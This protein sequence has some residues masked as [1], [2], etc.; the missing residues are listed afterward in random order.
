MVVSKKD[1]Q[2]DIPA[3]IRYL[4]ATLNADG[5]TYNV[6][7]SES[8]KARYTLSKM[9]IIQKL[10]AMNLLQAVEQFAAGDSELAIFVKD[11]LA[12]GVDLFRWDEKTIAMGEVLQIDL[13]EFFE[14][15]EGE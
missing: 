4:T 3:N 6:H 9:R 7:F 1:G 5:E 15:S 2:P 10:R 8:Q 14:L 11:W 13:D 12:Y